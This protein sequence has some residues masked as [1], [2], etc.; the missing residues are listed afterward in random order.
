MERPRSKSLAIRLI[1]RLRTLTQGPVAA[2][3]YRIRFHTGAY[4][5]ARGVCITKTTSG[6]TQLEVRR[7]GRVHVAFSVTPG[8]ALAALAGGKTSC[9]HD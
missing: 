8:R 9:K 7:A 4:F 6:M 5:A 1:Q 3:V 2:G